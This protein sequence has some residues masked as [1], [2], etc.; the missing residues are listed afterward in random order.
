VD[1]IYIDNSKQ[2]AAIEAPEYG[3]VILTAKNGKFVRSNT[4]VS[5]KTDIEI[6]DLAALNLPEYGSAELVI[7]AGKVVQCDTEA[8]HKLT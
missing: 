4:K 6:S 7:Y 1:K 5:H 3:K 2:T 8:T